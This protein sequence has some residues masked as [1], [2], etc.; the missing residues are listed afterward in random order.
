[1]VLEHLYKEVLLK[2]CD[3]R[4]ILLK[5]A[6]DPTLAELRAVANGMSKEEKYKRLVLLQN[7]QRFLDFDKPGILISCIF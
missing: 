4:Y 3:E 1:M 5:I 6:L 2:Y 7:R